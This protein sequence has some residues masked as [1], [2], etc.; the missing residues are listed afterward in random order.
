MYPSN[1]NQPHVMWYDKLDQMT[2]EE[3]IMCAARGQLVP[4]DTE[5]N[6]RVTEKLCVEGIVR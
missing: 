6:K 3:R 4:T 1:D 5:W 2:V